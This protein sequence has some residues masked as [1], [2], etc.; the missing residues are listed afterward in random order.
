M[1]CRSPW[2]LP[3]ILQ[4]SD[5]QLTTQLCS[6]RYRQCKLSMCCESWAVSYSL[7]LS[8]RIQKC[9]ETPDS[10][11]L[12]SSRFRKYQQNFLFFFFALL[13]CSCLSSYGLQSL[14]R[15]GSAKR[16]VNQPVLTRRLDHL[17]ITNQ[18]ANKWREKRKSAKSHQLGAWGNMSEENKTELLQHHL[19]DSPNS[20]SHWYCSIQLFRDL[21]V[22]WVLMRNAPTER[23]NWCGFG[24]LPFL[25]HNKG[26]KIICAPHGRVLRQRAGNWMSCPMKKSMKKQGLI[27]MLM[28]AASLTPNDWLQS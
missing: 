19:K 3:G 28:N 18:P 12:H 6:E 4:D 1:L 8:P 9:C 13:F 26:S 27:G 15:R 16:A 10:T 17:E 20:R 21:S 14:M 24:A 5:M 25:A 7:Q 22:R 2:Q 23:T 11:S